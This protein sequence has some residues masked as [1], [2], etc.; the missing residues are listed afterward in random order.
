MYFGKVKL[1]SITGGCCFQVHLFNTGQVII[2]HCH[3]TCLP[4]RLMKSLL[5]FVGVDKPWEYST[6]LLYLIRQ[7]IMYLCFRLEP[8]FYLLVLHWHMVQCSLKYGQ[9]ID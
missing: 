3:Q 6:Y 8:G 9:Y 7:V 2:D 5:L 1:N 4:A